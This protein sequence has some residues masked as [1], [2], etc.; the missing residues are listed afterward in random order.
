[1]LVMTHVRDESKCPGQAQLV[2]MD[3]LFDKHLNFK[4][5]SRLSAHLSKDDLNEQIGNGAIN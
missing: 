5:P 4:L 3:A 2:G 1:M